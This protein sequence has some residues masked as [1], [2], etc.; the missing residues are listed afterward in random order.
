MFQRPMRVKNGQQR[1]AH[2]DQA[3]NR[4]VGTWDS[5]GRL[6]GKHFTDEPG[7]YGTGQLAHPKNDQP[8]P[9]NITHVL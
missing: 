4:V 5:S 3:V 2:V 9:R 8:E 1:P 7:R 6:V